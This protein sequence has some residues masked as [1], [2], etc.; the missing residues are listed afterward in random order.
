MDNTR[1]R[2]AASTWR[3]GLR[4]RK[5]L[6]PFRTGKGR[7]ETPV[8]LDPGMGGGEG[9]RTQGNKGRFQ[10]IPAGSFL[11]VPSQPLQECGI[12]VRTLH[13]RGVPLGRPPGVPSRGS[14]GPGDHQPQSPVTWAAILQATQDWHSHV[15]ISEKVSY[16]LIL[17]RKKEKKK[18]KSSQE[19]PRKTSLTSNGSSK[20]LCW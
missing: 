11:Q 20:K 3:E 6:P 4:T 9:G 2:A 14:G 10:I 8:F 5:A 17:K 1:A 18:E 12:H 15:F 19:S 13:G 7:W 16:F